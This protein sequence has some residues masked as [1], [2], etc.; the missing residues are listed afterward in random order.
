MWGLVGDNRDGGYSSGHCHE[1]N[2]ISPRCACLPLRRR[3]VTGQVK[4]RETTSQRR[5][6]VVNRGTNRNESLDPTI[7]KCHV[8]KTLS[9][10]SVRI[11]SCFLSFNQAV[12]VISH[13]FDHFSF[14]NFTQAMFLYGRRILKLL[15]SAL[16]QDSWIAFVVCSGYTAPERQEKV[17]FWCFLV[18]RFEQLTFKQPFHQ[19]ELRWVHVAGGLTC[20]Y[21]YKTPSRFLK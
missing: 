9:E 8:S 10:T 5:D 17:K 7:K 19:D 18:S 21:R 2:Q 6:W 11:F 15:A 1:T 4:R 20:T 3:C 16:T 12:S 14:I 13:N